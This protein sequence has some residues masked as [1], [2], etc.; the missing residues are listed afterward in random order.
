N[1]TVEN[2]NKAEKPRKFSQ[3]P[4][5]LTKSGQVPVNAAKQS[6]HRAAASVSAARRVNI[7]ASRPNVNN[8][9]PTT[10]SY[11]KAHSPVQQSSMV[12]FDEMIQLKLGRMIDN[13]DQDAKITL[14]DETQG[15]MNEEEMFGVNDLDGDEVV[16]DVSASENIVRVLK[17]LK[18]KLVLLIQLLLLNEF[19]NTMAFAII[20]LATNQEFNFSKYI[21]DNMVKHLDGGV[22]FLMYLRFVQVFLD[23]QVEGID[24]SNAIFVI[25]F[26]TK[27]VLANMKR[28]GK[29]LSGKKKQ[30]SRRKHRRE[31]K[32]PLPSSEIP[33]EEGV[34]ITFNDP[35]P[36]DQIMI[37]EEVARNLE[38]QMQ[39]ELEEEERLAKNMDSSIGKMCLGPDIIEISSDWNEGSGD[40]DSPE[41][42]DTA[43]SGGKKEPG[44]LVFYKMYTEE[45]SD[46]RSFLRFAKEITNFGE[47]TITIQPEFDPFLLSSDEEGNPILDDLE[48]LLDFDFHEIPQIE[49][50]LPPMAD[51]VRL[52]GK[53][54][55]EEE[56]AMVKVKGQMI[57]EKNNL[58]AFINP[59]R[60]EGLINENALADTGYDINT[61]PYRIYEQLGRD[62]IMKE[63]RN[64]K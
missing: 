57:K 25:S 5:V 20:C 62:D 35:L 43:G 4:R 42:K 21:F 36:C 24:K 26:H 9:L 14:V 33:N 13:I 10:Y 1:T 55:P 40:W 37:D 53:I 46:R 17:L 16:V 7:A 56:R 38:A 52:D 60:L 6:S 2:E 51:R 32:V 58:G 8:A 64:I 41:Y 12:G 19:Y 39:A 48:M 30:I 47:G 23:N 22:K 3:R 49:T 11:F 29:D 15:R 61:M 54:K 63:D 44:A 59:I 27:E 18:K 34:P 50:D 28:E 45:D 31:I